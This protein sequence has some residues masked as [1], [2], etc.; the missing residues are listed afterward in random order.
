MY[1]LVLEELMIEDRVKPTMIKWAQ[2]F[3]RIIIL[4][5]WDDIWSTNM[6]IIK[7]ISVREN[8][9]KMFYR[10]HYTPVKLALIYQNNSGK[11][12]KCNKEDGTYL[13]CWWTCKM[14]KSYWIMVHKPNMWR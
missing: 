1:P 2:N 6:K 3:E 8:I 4:D 5:E 11:C 14:I 7:S 9:I 12:W 10:W 13:H